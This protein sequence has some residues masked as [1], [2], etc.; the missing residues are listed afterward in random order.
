MPG[1]AGCWL[2]AP[3]PDRFGLL[4]GRTLVNTSR[5]A[6]PA[7]VPRSEASRTPQPRRQLPKLRDVTGQIEWV[8]GLIGQMTPEQRK[9]LAGIVN[10]LMPTVNQLF[11]KVQ[12]IPGVAE[13]LKPIIDALKAKLAMLAV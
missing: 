6:S 12:T 3:L 1:R 7:W 4:I 8:D 10:P 13:P 2:T 11:D 9:L 5:I